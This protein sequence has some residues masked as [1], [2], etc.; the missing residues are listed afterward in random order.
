MPK[1]DFN[2]HLWLAASALRCCQI[3]EFP[4]YSFGLVLFL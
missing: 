4:F 3:S 1:C 2:E